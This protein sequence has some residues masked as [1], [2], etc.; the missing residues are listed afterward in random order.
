MPDFSSYPQVKGFL[1]CVHIHTNAMWNLQHT[2][3]LVMSEFYRMDCVGCDVLQYFVTE[4]G[5]EWDYHDDGSG[6]ITNARQRQISKAD[7]HNLDRAIDELPA[8]N[9]LPWLSTLVIVSHREGTNWVVH[10]YART[11][12][13]TKEFPALRKILDI[14]GER[15]ETKEV[16]PF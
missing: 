7:F 6:A 16:H 15:P 11:S 9:Q 10:S 1:S 13:E 14:I 12:T 8:T 2:N 4:D 3:F 5:H